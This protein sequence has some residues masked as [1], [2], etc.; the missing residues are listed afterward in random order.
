MTAKKSPAKRPVRSTVPKTLRIEVCVSRGDYWAK[1]ETTA[2]HVVDVSRFLIATVRT[3]AAEAPDLLPH[4][5]KVPGDV[6]AYD[7]AEEVE[8]SAKV[9]VKPLGFR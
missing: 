4:V 3:L 2:E 1:C 7:W 6:L 9:S 8:G 5:E